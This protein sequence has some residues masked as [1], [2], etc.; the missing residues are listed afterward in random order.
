MQVSFQILVN[1]LGE[2]QNEPFYVLQSIQARVSQELRRPVAVGPSHVSAVQ[3]ASAQ[4]V[5]LCCE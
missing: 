1:E 4:A 5:R 3:S 2:V